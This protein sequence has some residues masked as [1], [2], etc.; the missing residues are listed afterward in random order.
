[1]KNIKLVLLCF[2]LFV[3]FSASAFAKYTGTYYGYD[4]SGNF[5]EM[6][7]IRTCEES[8]ARVGA[9]HRIYKGEFSSKSELGHFTGTYSIDG[10]QMRF[11][12]DNVSKRAGATAYFRTQQE[13]T[14]RDITYTKE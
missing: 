4:K 12:F 7:T 6:I 11:S 14:Y 2:G 3:V 13:F 1:M 10:R 8:P 9:N 5:V